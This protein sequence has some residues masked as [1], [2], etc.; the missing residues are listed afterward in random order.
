[1]KGGPYASLRSVGYHF[2]R[3]S[4]H[5]IPFRLGGDAVEYYHILAK[6]V[7]DDW[8][9]LKHVLGQR[10]DCISHEPVYLS[11]MLTL[12]EIEF[13]RHADYVKEC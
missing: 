8:F 5:R 4:R 6:V 1:M 11:R 9:E 3:R 7:E 13:P 10:F 12:R 2:T